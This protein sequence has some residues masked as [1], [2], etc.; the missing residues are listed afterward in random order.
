MSEF[1]TI[2]YEIITSIFVIFHTKFK[3][4]QTIAKYVSLVSFNIY[5]EIC[6]SIIDFLNQLSFRIV[7]VL[8]NDTIK[9]N[10]NCR[11]RVDI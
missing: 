2:S 4:N 6:Q 3:L 11:Y 5:V 7:E 10:Y 9:C 1:D 8:R